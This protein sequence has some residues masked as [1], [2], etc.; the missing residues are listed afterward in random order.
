MAQTGPIRI[1]LSPELTAKLRE[2]REELVPLIEDANALADAAEELLAFVP[3]EVSPVVIV[4][5]RL[6]PLQAALDSFRG[7]AAVIAE[8]GQ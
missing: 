8:A 5:D 4:R 1:E 7:H 3:G 6:A 2:V